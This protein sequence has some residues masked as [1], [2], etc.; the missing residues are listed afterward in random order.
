MMKTWKL[1]VFMTK[2]RCRDQIHLCMSASVEA[3]T[4]NTHFYFSTTHYWLIPIID[5]GHIMH[6][7]GGTNDS[8]NKN[9]SH[10]ECHQNAWSINSL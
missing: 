9:S 3:A 4:F 2:E 6:N 10:E 8:K 1:S 5:F 7:K